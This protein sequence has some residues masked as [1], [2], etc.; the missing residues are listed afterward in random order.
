MNINSGIFW[1]TMST[2]CIN[3]VLKLKQLITT[4]CLYVITMYYIQIRPLLLERSSLT[5][6]QNTECR[7][8][9][10]LVRYMII[11]YSQMHRAYKYSQHSSIIWP[12]WLN[13]WVFVYELS[14][15]GFVFSCWHLNYILRSQ[16]FAL[17]RSYFLNGMF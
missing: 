8:T 12:V 11:T 15:C 9:L 5:F 3:A 16:K 1:E 7:F 10:K 14:S 4:S 17:V 6:R 13:H 2:L